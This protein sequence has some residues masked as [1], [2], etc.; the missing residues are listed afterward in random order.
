M[1]YA[2]RGAPD[3]APAFSHFGSRDFEQKIGNDAL[4][5]A[6]TN[7]DVMDTNPPTSTGETDPR[8]PPADFKSRFCEE[9]GCA[10]A[11]FEERA[12]AECLYPVARLLAPVIR[13]LRPNYFAPDLALIGYLGKS[14]SRRNA[15]NELAAF[16]E[17][18]E[19]R[20]SFARKTLRIRISARRT[21]QL[22]ARLF[23]RRAVR[24]AAGVTQRSAV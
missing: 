10:P 9:F 18:N 11:Q 13:I 22:T 24:G 17:S 14:P 16:M 20:G 5:L 3:G 1:M 6:T 7:H 21:S 4:I 12:F 19:A 2:E 15:M 8:N 23:D